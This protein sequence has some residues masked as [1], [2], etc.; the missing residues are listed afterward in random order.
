MLPKW[1]A[2]GHGERGR[3]I[4]AEG[5]RRP[6]ASPQIARLDR[7][8]GRSRPVVRFAVTN[9]CIRRIERMHMAARFTLT[10]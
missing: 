2:G 3:L 1:A 8:S 10:R 4:A 9:I 6:S 5:M 7:A